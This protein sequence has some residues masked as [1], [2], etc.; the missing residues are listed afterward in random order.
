MSTFQ[1]FLG[2]FLRIGPHYYEFM[3]HP[4][5]PN[6]KQAVFVIEGGEALLYQLREMA[7]HTLYALKVIKPAYRTEHIARVTDALARQP[8]LSGLAL[9]QRIC[10]TKD[11]YRNVIMTFPE[12]EYAILMPWL[13]GRTWAGLLLDPATS[14]RYS[15]GQAKDLALATANILW[16]LETRRMA[17][18]DIAGGNVLLSADLKQIMLLD[19]E[20]MYIHDIPAPKIRSQGSPGYQHRHPGPHGQHCAEGDRFAGAILLTEMLTWCDPHVRALVPDETEALFRPGDL[21]IIGTPLWRAVR[22]ALWALSPEL[23]QLFDQA[24]ASATLAECPDLASWCMALL[25]LR[26]W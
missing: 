4:L 10:L 6:D 17:H 13:E 3:P 2:T 23:L 25:A 15:V 8:D 7:T 21:Q 14:A 9:E 16:N 11:A 26:A 20:G 1:P 19:I 18:A 5:F 22:N 24:W 12:L